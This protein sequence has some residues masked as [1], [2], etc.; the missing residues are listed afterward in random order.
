MP[1]MSGYST[2]EGKSLVW[3]NPGQTECLRV[4][5]EDD[6]SFSRGRRADWF[7]F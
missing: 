6:V 7:L 3:S 1:E 5:E 4:C 2:K